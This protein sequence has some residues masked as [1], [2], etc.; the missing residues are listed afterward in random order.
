M[1]KR[2]AIGIT[3]GDPAGIGAEIIV[4][5]LAK[6]S[7]YERS[8]PVVIGDYEALVDAIRFCHSALHVNVIN[9][10]SE[11]KGEYGTIDLI[12]LGYLKPG[13]WEYKKV[14]ALCGEASFQ[15][16]V[17]AIEL[18]KKHEI[19]AVIT[20]PINKESINLAGHHYSGRITIRLF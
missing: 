18:A 16:V 12:N 5:S 20:A 13:S 8:V 14:S 11:A 1:N 19:E 4:K 10:V 15:Y 17:Y 6:E 2:I 3:M 9:Q 7:V